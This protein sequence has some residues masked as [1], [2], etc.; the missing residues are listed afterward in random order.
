M[1]FSSY[2]PSILPRIHRFYLQ[3]SNAPSVPANAILPPPA[4]SIPTTVVDRPHNVFN[5]DCL[6]RQYVTEWA[7]ES[8][9]AK[10]ALRRLHRQVEA[11]RQKKFHAHSPIEIRFVR[12]DDIWLSPAYGHQMVCYIGIIVY[13]YIDTMHY[14]TIVL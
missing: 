7:V 10:E 3:H 12:G 4:D 9:K 8:N 6:F 13:R 1:Y 2:T 14:H 5:F 11:D